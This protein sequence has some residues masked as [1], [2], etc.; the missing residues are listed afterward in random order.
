MTNTRRES[1]LGND[2][3][4]AFLTQ[5]FKYAGVLKLARELCS[6]ADGEE[7]TA[8]QDITYKSLF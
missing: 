3:K 6:T 2:Q 5:H 1:A 4:A 7:D 8:R